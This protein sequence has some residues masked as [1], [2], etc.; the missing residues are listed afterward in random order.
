MTRRSSQFGPSKA[1]VSLSCWP[2]VSVYCLVATTALLQPPTTHCAIPQQYSTMSVDDIT[3]TSAEAERV[4]RA[5]RSPS[6]KESLKL[7]SDDTSFQSHKTHSLVKH[8][9]FSALNRTF[10]LQLWPR[11]ILTDHPS[12][13]IEQSA[14]SQSNS[15]TILHSIEQLS[16]SFLTGYDV[17]QSESSRVD[18]FVDQSGFITG[19]L[20]Y[21]HS[22]DVYIEPVWRHKDVDALANKD[23]R[24]MIVFYGSGLDDSAWSPDVDKCGGYPEAAR[25]SE[26]HEPIISRSLRQNILK[27]WTILQIVIF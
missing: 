24:S 11:N 25:F 21:E 14:N 18:L 17:N 9:S 4:Q 16:T 20:S 7:K 10:Y 6:D 15:S 13:V 19:S 26:E 23:A 5:A 22:N 2:V 27:K 12:L 3:V 1:E 8:I